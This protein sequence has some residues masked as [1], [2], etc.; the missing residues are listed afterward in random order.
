MENWR[1]FRLQRTDRR[2]GIC[3][4]KFI[5][6]KRIKNGLWKRMITGYD[7]ILQFGN[8]TAGEKKK[9]S[10]ESKRRENLRDIFGDVDGVI[11]FFCVIQRDDFCGNGGT[12]TLLTGD[13][14]CRVVAG[15]EKIRIITSTSVKKRGESRDRKKNPRRRN[16][17]CHRFGALGFRNSNKWYRKDK[18]IDDSDKDL[19]PITKFL[20]F[21]MQIFQN[22]N[23]SYL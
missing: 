2:N 20:N 10:W 12:Y 23:Y 9:K 16:H 6:L 21:L 3:L 18:Q 8:R 1:K 11:G 15:G 17:H 7:L 19:K 14:E 22:E 13:F 5:L 4:I